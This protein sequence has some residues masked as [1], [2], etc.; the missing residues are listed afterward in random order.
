MVYLEKYEIYN[1]SF[2]KYTQNS[3]QIQTTKVLK[4]DTGEYFCN[5]DVKRKDR[6][7][8][9]LKLLMTKNMM[10]KAKR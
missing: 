7:D 5:P 9:I 10:M 6:L 4:E 1:I 2:Q 3:K 8:Y